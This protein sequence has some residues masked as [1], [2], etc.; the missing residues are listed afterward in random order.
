MEEKE[1][2]P[3]EKFLSEIEQIVRSGQFTADQHDYFKEG[4]NLIRQS[5]PPSEQSDD[6]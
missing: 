3:A 5:I 6:S 2:E 4:F 1:Q